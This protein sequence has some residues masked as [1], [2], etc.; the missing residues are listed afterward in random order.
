MMQ[1]ARAGMT[2]VELLVAMAAVALISMMLVALMSSGL[3]L[4][5]AAERQRKVY[6]RARVVF[7]YLEGDL[8]TALTRDPPGSAV[9]NRLFCAPDP[10]GRQVLMITRTF[11]TGSERGLAFTAG[12]GLD[13]VDR[14]G[15]GEKPR[16]DDEDSD[17][18]SGRADEELYNFKD[19]DG[20]GRVDEDLAPLAGS[21]QVVYLLEGRELKRGLRAPAGADFA[22]MFK[23]SSVLCREVIYFGMLFATPYSRVQYGGLDA[24]DREL[25]PYSTSWYAGLPLLPSRKKPRGPF[26]VERLWDSTRGVIPGFSFYVGPESK[27]DGEDDVFPE[28][29]RVT[30]VVEPHELRTVRSDTLGYVND[31][32]GLI[33]VASTRG[34]PP[35]GRADSYVLVDDEWMHYSSKDDRSFT[36]DGRGA[37]GTAAAVHQRGASVRRG[38]TFTRTFYIPGYRSEDA[39]VVGKLK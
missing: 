24:R 27:D 34:F 14:P 9:R 11:G 21:A 18:R 39:S 13:V 26:G 30:L 32:T 23:D 31:S 8:E 28:L 20:D 38:Y 37:R 7:S 19:D 36:V 12:D 6:T 35:G 10:A 16:P 33:P 17:P 22:S 3:G 5:S 15:A 29:V 2:L 4:W 25:G 1:R